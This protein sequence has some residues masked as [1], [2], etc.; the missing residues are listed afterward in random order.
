M[1][2]RRCQGGFPACGRALWKAGD[3]CSAGGGQRSSATGLWIA[4]RNSA[5]FSASSSSSPRLASTRRRELSTVRV[6]A[7]AV[8]PADLRQREVG[9]LA[10]EED[11]HLAGAQRGGGAAGADQLGAGDAEAFGDLLLDLLDRGRLGGAVRAGST[12]AISS[13]LSGLAIS[14]AWAM[15]RVSAPCSWRTLASIRLAS[16]VEGA[17]VGDLDPGL[18]DQ[19]A[20][21]GQPGRQVGRLD[22]DGQAPLEAVAQARGE[23]RELARDPVG[24]EDQLAAGLI[25]GVEGVEELLLGGGLALEELDVV[26]QQHV[27]VAVAGLEGLGCRSTCSAPT[28]SLVNDSAVV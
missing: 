26:D 14:E 21:D 19:A 12:S 25:E 13:E 5:T 27:D 17:G 6:I 1:A 10:G 18:L 8:E 11:R 24:G 4:A 23:G 15:T 2:I 16:S 22:G 7:A 9:Q 28:N 20:Q 3:S